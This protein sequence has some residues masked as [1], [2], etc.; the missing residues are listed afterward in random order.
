MLGQPRLAAARHPMRA[1]R[2]GTCQQK[3]RP[4][5]DMRVALNFVAFKKPGG[6][7]HHIYH[8]RLP[9]PMRLADVHRCGKR[10]L[11]LMAFAFRIQ[12]ANQIEMA[13]HKKIRMMTD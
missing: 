4:R 11:A 7:I 6:R 10:L 1:A 9:V 13:G 3:P 2:A 5:F 8:E 12:T